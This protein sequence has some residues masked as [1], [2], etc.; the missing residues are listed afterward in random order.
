MS[1]DTIFVSSYFL[2]NVLENGTS[3]IEPTFI[4]GETVSGERAKGEQIRGR[5]GDGEEKVFRCEVPLFISAQ[6][7]IKGS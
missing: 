1:D 3:N 7:L 5:R 2:S 4:I 6:R